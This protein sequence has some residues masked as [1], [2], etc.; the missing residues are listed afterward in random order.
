LTVTPLFEPMIAQR[1]LRLDR[2]GEEALRIL[3][4]NLGR[5]RWEAVAEFREHPRCQEARAR[6]REFE[7]RAAASEPEDAAAFSRG[8]AQEVTT[9]IDAGAGRPPNAYRSRT[10]PK[11]QSRPVSQ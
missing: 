10:P 3:V 1:G 6:L 4:P 7:E 8:V 11:R 2:P 9:C 5:L